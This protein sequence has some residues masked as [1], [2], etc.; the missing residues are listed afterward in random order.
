MTLTNRIYPGMLDRAIEF[1][2]VESE[3]YF[4]QKGQIKCFNEMSY[5]VYAIVKNHI[6]KDHVLTRTL[7][8]WHPDNETEQVYQFLKC[9]YGGLDFKADIKDNKLQDGDYWEC[10]KRAT[11]SFNGIVCKAPQYNG[12]NLTSLDV[13]LMKLLS[14]NETNESIAQQLHI[15]MGSFHKSKK[16]LYEK[17]GN[18]QTKQEITKINMSLNLI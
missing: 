14:T 17:L 4:I 12:H 8:T 15:P 11:C 5:G 13:K 9:R 1:F 2:T 10:P 16:I 18:V 7:K 3:G 6:S